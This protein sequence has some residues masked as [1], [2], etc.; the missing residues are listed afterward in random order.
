MEPRVDPIRKV[1]SP[2]WAAIKTDNLSGDRHELCRGINQ[3][4]VARAVANE[5]GRF[6]DAICIVED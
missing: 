5:R 2:Q 4:D 1:R 6:K 3:S